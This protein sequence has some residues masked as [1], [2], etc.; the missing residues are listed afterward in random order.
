MHTILKKIEGSAPWS[1]KNFNC[2]TT[3]ANSSIFDL[4]FGLCWGNWV[5]SYGIS[6]ANIWERNGVPGQNSTFGS[7]LRRPM[8]P[9]LSIQQW[10]SSARFILNLRTVRISILKKIVKGQPHR[11]NFF[12]CSTRN[13]MSSIVNLMVGLCLENWVPSNDISQA[14]ICSVMAPQGKIVVFWDV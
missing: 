13:T 3:N 1:Q 9:Y 4:V 11:V 10:L 2:S 6:Q 8:V 5:L 14:E 7:P 12:N